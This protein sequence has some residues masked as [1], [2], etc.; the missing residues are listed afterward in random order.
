M[1][2]FN[3]TYDWLLGIGFEQ[4]K[5][6]GLV[7]ALQSDGWEVELTYTTDGWAAQISRNGI[8]G[9]SFFPKHLQNKKEIGGLLDAL[10][11]E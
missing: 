7:L 1:F 10:G 8:R 5:S 6:S 3:K 4:K 11:I 2:V 9:T